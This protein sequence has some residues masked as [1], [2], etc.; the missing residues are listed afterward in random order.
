MCHF[1]AM[2]FSFAPSFPRWVLGFQLKMLS[3]LCSR[4]RLG[5]SLLKRYSGLREE[6]LLSCASRKMELALF[7]IDQV[8]LQGGGWIHLY[9][10]SISVSFGRRHLLRNQIESRRE[11]RQRKSVRKRYQIWTG[12]ME[13]RTRGAT[14]AGVPSDSKTIGV[15]SC[16]S[17]GLLRKCLFFK[18]QG[19]FGER[20]SLY[21]VA[22]MTGAWKKDL[23]G[24]VVTHAMRPSRRLWVQ[25]DSPGLHA[26]KPNMTRNCSRSRRRSI[27][28]TG[29]CNDTLV[30]DQSIWRDKL[31]APAH[32]QRPSGSCLPA[33]YPFGHRRF[34]GQGGDALAHRISSYCCSLAIAEVRIQAP[35]SAFISSPFRR[36]IRPRGTKCFPSVP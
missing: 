6:C 30:P 31:L 14:A 26:L 4:N 2:S 17:V 25:V 19:L 34:T 15:P 32:P 27:G 28:D 9:P 13:S 11:V 24:L 23:G 12:W 1:S 22:K 10:R 21:T 29:P 36:P 33:A 35:C 20:V 5:T 7:Q 8:A 3:L 18:N 16:G